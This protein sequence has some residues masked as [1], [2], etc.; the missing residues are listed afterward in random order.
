M[1]I[2]MRMLLKSVLLFTVCSTAACLFIVREYVVGT[3]SPR[4]L[5]IALVVLWL[6]SMCAFVLIGL[7]VRAPSR[8]GSGSA[9]IPKP[10]GCGGTSATR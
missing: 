7:R 2:N 8:S 6:A 3:L 4:G 10:P 5:G 9:S 1:Q